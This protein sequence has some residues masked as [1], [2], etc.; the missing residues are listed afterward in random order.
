MK[1]SKAVADKIVALMGENGY[2]RRNVEIVLGL[3]E[4]DGDLERKLAKINEAEK[5]DDLWPFINNEN[6]NSQVRK[7]ARERMA[8]LLFAEFEA[9]K[10]SDIAFEAQFDIYLD[11]RGK[12]ISTADGSHGHPAAVHAREIEGAVQVMLLSA[13]NEA[14]TPDKCHDIC[15]FAFIAEN[16][17]MHRR[18]F[19]KGYGLCKQPKD[20][21]E[22]AKGRGIR[23]LSD[24]YG[25]C[26]T[27]AAEMLQ[28]E[29]GALAAK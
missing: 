6:D 20:F 29:E 5:S 9:A 24:E 8:T 1:T 17:D 15:Y 2:D 3:R 23:P 11:L 12:L 10:K 4:K 14:N 7:H 18:A 21:L 28:K 13:L 19:E 22:L 26:V 16:D 27:A 25:R